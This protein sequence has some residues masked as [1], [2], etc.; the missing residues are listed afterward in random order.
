MDLQLLA[1]AI[2]LI[3]LSSIYFAYRERIAG[4]PS[5][6]FIQARNRSKIV[7]RIATKSRPI[8]IKEIYVRK[9]I[10]YILYGGKTKLD[11]TYPKYPNGTIRLTTSS[12]DDYVVNLPMECNPNNTYKIFVRTTGGNCSI[13]RKKDDCVT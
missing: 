10:W 13:I 2:S 12:Q 6:S 8:E 7:L 3:G 4:S 9:Q 5:L 1:V 11:W